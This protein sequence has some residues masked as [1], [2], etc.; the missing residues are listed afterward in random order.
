MSCRSYISPDQLDD[1]VTKGVLIDIR[2]QDE[3]DAG[4]I[5]GAF[6]IPLGILALVIEE[7]ISEKSTPI[8]LYCRTGGRTI[9]G[10][11][12]LY[13]LGYTDVSILRG[14]YEEYKRRFK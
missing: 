2:E 7:R 6:H 10:Y 8:V 12:L 9:F 5:V 11:D 13:D 1:Y 3:W 14:G 4:Y